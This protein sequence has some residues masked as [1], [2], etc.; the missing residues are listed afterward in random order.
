MQRS[1]TEELEK[2]VEFSTFVSFSLCIGPGQ[3]FEELLEA[4]EVR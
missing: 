3:W 1:S 2:H 4:V